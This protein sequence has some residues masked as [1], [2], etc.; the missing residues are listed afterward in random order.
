MARRRRRVV[1]VK[2]H[3]GLDVAGYERVKMKNKSFMSR[4]VHNG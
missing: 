3:V 2:A 4:L 1:P